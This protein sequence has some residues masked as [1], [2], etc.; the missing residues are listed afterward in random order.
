M[1]KRWDYHHAPGHDDWQ[2][3]QGGAYGTGGHATAD[4]DSVGGREDL[5]DEFIPFIG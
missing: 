1:Y 3:A 2:S 4:V 5:D